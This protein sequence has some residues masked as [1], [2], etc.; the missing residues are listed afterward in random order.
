[1]QQE[2]LLFALVATVAPVPDVPV[3]ATAALNSLGEALLLPTFK[4]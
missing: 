2:Q 1:M 4:I 3:V